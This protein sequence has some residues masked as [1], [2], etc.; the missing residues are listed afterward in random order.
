MSI[1][2]NLL[3]KPKAKRATVEF[4]PGVT[5]DGY[6][7]LKTDEFRA[8][9]YGASLVLGYAENWL[10]RVI[11][12]S[13]S[14]YQKRDKT[15]E[16]LTHWGFSNLPEEVEIVNTGE[17]RGRN[18]ATTISLTDFNCLI[19]YAAIEGKKKQ[20]IALDMGLRRVAL[21]V[22]FRN[23]FGIQIDQSVLHPFYQEYAKGLCWTDEDRQDI[24]DSYVP[25]D[26]DSFDYNTLRDYF[27]N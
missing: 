19:G 4:C 26:A 22:F 14:T 7:L 2:S 16:S 18:W 24:R 20:A 25:G 17:G 12:S 27:G 10:Y 8:G 9:I 11:G 21:E 5:V 13:Q 6:R 23:A 1:L 3:P 15:L